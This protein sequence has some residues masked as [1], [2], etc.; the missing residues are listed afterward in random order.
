MSQVLS[1]K[2]IYTGPGL[3]KQLS[4]LHTNNNP[5]WVTTTKK[6]I[7]YNGTMS[8]KILFSKVEFLHLHM[9]LRVVLFTGKI[10]KRHIDMWVCV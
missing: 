9:E 2:V 3:V 5:T 7:L 10:R 4:T 8:K 6:L 1:L